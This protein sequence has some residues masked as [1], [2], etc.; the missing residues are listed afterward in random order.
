MSD[1]VDWDEWYQE[2][3][4]GVCDEAGVPD[5]DDDVLVD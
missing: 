5:E 2:H 3:P 4:S 1:R